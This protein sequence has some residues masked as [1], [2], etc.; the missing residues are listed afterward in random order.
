VLNHTIPKP[1]IQK[2]I[3]RHIRLQEGF[4][5]Q[6]FSVTGV[7]KLKIPSTLLRGKKTNLV[8]NPT[9]V[10]QHQVLTAFA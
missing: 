7:A 6:E 4:Q 3:F 8:S 1:G 10:P 9:P 2:S 5:N